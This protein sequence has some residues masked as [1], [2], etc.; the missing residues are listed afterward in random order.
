MRLP[1]TLGIC[2]ESSAKGGKSAEACQKCCNDNQIK[3]GLPPRQLEVCIQRCMIG[4]A[5]NC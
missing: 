5:R 3:M 4:A 1:L 2:E